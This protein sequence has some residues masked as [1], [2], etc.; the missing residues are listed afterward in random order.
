VRMGLQLKNKIRSAAYAVEWRV[1]Q[2]AGATS[3]PVCPGVTDYQT[4]YRAR[5]KPRGIGSG[6]WYSMRLECRPVGT[7]DGT[8]YYEIRT[9]VDGTISARHV[10]TFDHGGFIL[11]MSLGKVW[12]DDVVIRELVPIKEP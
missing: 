8:P 4:V 5:K 12:V 10:A 11:D 1:A 3:G 7:L 6:E 9:F 2:A